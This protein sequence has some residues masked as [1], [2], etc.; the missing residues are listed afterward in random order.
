[1]VLNVLT[2][3][4]A[5]LDD[6]HLRRHVESPLAGSGNSRRNV[7][8]TVLRAGHDGLLSGPVRT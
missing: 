7:S 8:R 1:M 5:T 3:L 4:S 2:G 6:G